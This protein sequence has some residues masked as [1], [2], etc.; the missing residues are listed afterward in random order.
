MSQERAQWRRRL[1]EG[2]EEFQQRVR[3]FNR[4]M[5]RSLEHYTNQMDAST[6]N[7]RHEVVELL[8]SIVRV[9][10]EHDDRLDSMR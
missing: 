2:Y 3:D 1:R 10:R 8:E 5:D 7:T 6:N 9:V 4:D